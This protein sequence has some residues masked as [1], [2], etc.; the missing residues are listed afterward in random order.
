MVSDQNVTGQAL[1]NHL[2][3]GIR[4]RSTFV[5]LFGL[6]LSP[7]RTIKQSGTQHSNLERCNNV[8]Q[9]GR[10]YWMMLVEHFLIDRELAQQF[11]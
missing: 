2:V 9:F 6:L 5:N 8:Q 3:S 4:L 7:G 11:Y 1:V 10:L